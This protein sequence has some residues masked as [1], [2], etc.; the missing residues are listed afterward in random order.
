MTLAELFADGCFF[1]LACPL[2][3]RFEPRLR[4]GSGDGV[5]LSRRRGRRE[6]PLPCAQRSGQVTASL[7]HFSLEGEEF[8]AAGLGARCG[9]PRLSRGPRLE[10]L[11]EKTPRGVEVVA[12]KLSACGLD[13]QGVGL[14]DLPPGEKVASDHLGQGTTPST[15]PPLQRCSGCTSISGYEGSYRRWKCSTTP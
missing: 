5:T 11:A 9:Q 8:S 4:A 3:C 2:L 10:G 12:A 6:R 13:E 1:P 14:R 7:E 15:G